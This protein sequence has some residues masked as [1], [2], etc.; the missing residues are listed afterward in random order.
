[1]EDQNDEPNHKCKY[2]SGKSN[3]HQ[4]TGYA[5]RIKKLTIIFSV[6]DAGMNRAL[7]HMA[8]V[9]A[10]DYTTRDHGAHRRECDKNDE[11]ENDPI[12][13]PRKTFLAR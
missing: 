5:E 3:K 6:D 2:S 12:K 4:P 1:M 9:H 7:V 13:N 11:S 8:A 10:S